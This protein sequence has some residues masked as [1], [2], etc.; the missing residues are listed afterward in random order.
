[1]KTAT[2]GDRKQ[3]GD[4]IL[5]D[6]VKAGLETSVPAETWVKG[7]GVMGT[8]PSKPRD[9]PEQRAQTRPDGAAMI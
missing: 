8:E 4:G 3:R 2:D 1:M 7:E 5:K 6:M 9:L